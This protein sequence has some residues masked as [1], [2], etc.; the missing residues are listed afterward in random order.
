MVYHCNFQFCVYCG[1][2]AIA[3]RL[4]GFNQGLD[5]VI[6][7]AAATTTAALTS[8]IYGN[9][10]NTS[11]NRGIRTPAAKISTRIQRI[12]IQNQMLW[13]GI[14]QSDYKNLQKKSQ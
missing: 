9:S 13:A 2:Q 6:G 1:T 14:R 5:N 8:S 12:L 3:F 11:R 4:A 7:P 10:P